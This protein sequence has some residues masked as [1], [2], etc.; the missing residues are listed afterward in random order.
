MPQPREFYEAADEWL[1]FATGDLLAA[2]LSSGFE[3]HLEILCF[4]SQQCVEKSLK[5]V[6][7]A[8]GQDF[9]RT[10]NISKLVEC[11]IDAG[12][13]APDYLLQSERL[14]RFAVMLRY[15]SSGLLPN[16]DEHLQSAQIAH[17]TLDWAKAKVEGLKL[18]DTADGPTA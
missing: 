6:L 17:K 11:L 5:A 13:E 18:S 7:V 1:H 12:V 14:S 3:L 2:E 9:P 10:H 15:P 8:M 16:K 4:H